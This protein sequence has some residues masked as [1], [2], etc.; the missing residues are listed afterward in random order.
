MVPPWNVSLIGLQPATDRRWTS[1]QFK[2]PLFY[3]GKQVRNSNNSNKNNN[4]DYSNGNDNDNDG[5]NYNDFLYFNIFS[6][7]DL[8]IRWSKSPSAAMEW[9][10]FP[11]QISN[12]IITGSQ[13]NISPHN[14][15]SILPFEHLGKVPFHWPSF[16]QTIV[17]EPI[18]VKPLAQVNQ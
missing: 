10:N 17:F 13:K 14:L 5:D 7:G 16:P 12:N 8:A 9:A 3:V 18:S 6:V 1:F 15:S 4:N 11:L 2:T